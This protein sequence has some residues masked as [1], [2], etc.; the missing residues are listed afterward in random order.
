MLYL[1]LLNLIQFGSYKSQNFIKSNYVTEHGAA[2]VQ[3]MFYK[4]ERLL[5]L[6]ILFN[7]K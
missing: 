7:R 2:K 3:D 4:I 6:L 1:S 5:K